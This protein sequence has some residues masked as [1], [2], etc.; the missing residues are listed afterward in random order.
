MCRSVFSVKKTWLRLTEYQ[1]H[2]GV[3]AVDCVSFFASPNS[4]GVVGSG[5]IVANEV[6]LDKANMRT[7][8]LS[9]DFLQQGFVIS[10]VEVSQ[11]PR[12]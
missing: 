10:F 12:R 1:Q 9:D 6:S 8:S 7:A 4:K 5:S 11:R 2:M 3:G